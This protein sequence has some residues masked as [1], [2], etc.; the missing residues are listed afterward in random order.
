MRLSALIPTKYPIKEELTQE[1]AKTSKNSSENKTP[2]TTGI[3][4]T[5]ESPAV[6]RAMLA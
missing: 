5:A 6:S 1:T 2:P 3:L 4:T